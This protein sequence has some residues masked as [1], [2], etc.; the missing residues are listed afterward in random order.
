MIRLAALAVVFGA[1]WPRSGAAGGGRIACLGLQEGPCR[2]PEPSRY[3]PAPPGSPPE[4]FPV[5][6]ANFGLLVPAPAGDSWQFVCDDRYGVAPPDRVW[7]DPGGRLFAG[8]RIGLL[9]SDD[10]C[11]WQ[12]ARGE[13]DGVAVVDV[14]FDPQTTGRM[15]ALGLSPPALYRSLDGGGTFSRQRIFP[16]TFVYPRLLSAPSDGRRLYVVAATRGAST[17]LETTADGGETWS[18]LELTAGIAP[19][20]RNPLGPI[21]VTPDDPATLYFVLPDPEGDEIWKSGDGGRS[22][23]RV[24][25]LRDGELL[26]GFAFGA[27][28]AT[29][30]VAGSAPIRLE[31]RPPARLYVS[32]D[33]AGTWDEPIASGAGGPFYRCLAFAGGLLAACGAGESGGDRFL[34]GVSSD[35]G[36]NWSPLVRLG[37][38]AGARAC[39]RSQCIA[40]EEWLCDTYRRCS[41]RPDASAELPPSPP[42]PPDAAA[43]DTA[44]TDLR[45][46]G[47]G[48][49]CQLGRRQGADSG[50]APAAL[51]LSALLVLLRWRP[52][53]P[54]ARLARRRARAGCALGDVR[55]S[56]VR[57]RRLSEVRA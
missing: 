23:A 33:G 18:S 51:F 5:V 39:A 35:E 57:T 55:Y 21:A 13:L 42:A 14:A 47:G 34:I 38:L 2:T 25:V 19:P 56:V 37:D 53:R 41:G 44:D 32:R 15:W 11:D 52:V 49:A 29:L 26:A 45:S 7:R 22:V 50:G 54:R 46:R 40:T 17:T 1:F 31:D 30:F 12:A 16:D 28:A 10:G 24:L 20:L 48:C 27:T 43:P 3:F 36:R 4:L 8:G 6:V 9:A